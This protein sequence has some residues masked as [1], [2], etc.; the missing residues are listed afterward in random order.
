LPDCVDGEGVPTFSSVAEL[1]WPDVRPDRGAGDG[2]GSWAG[3]ATGTGTGG[4]DTGGAG[5]G[6]R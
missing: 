3:S 5:T 4:A 6:V 2:D 1:E